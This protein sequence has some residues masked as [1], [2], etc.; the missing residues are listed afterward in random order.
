[1]PGPRH[2]KGPQTSGQGVATAK[3][4]GLFVE[5]NPE[6][7]LLGMDETEDD[8][9][10]EAELLALTGEAESTSRKPAPKGKT[11]L[12]MAHI[13]KLAA[14]CMRDEE[15]HEDDDEEGL[16]EDTD[17]LTEL[18]EVLG[19]SE[20]AELMDGDE[21]A[22][23][24]VCEEKTQKDTDPAV[25]T[26]LL[27]A[28]VSAV[29]AGG[30][31]GLQ[32][33]L[34]ERIQNYQHAAASAKEAGEA[35]KARR[36]ERGLKTLESQLANVR[37]GRKINEEEIPPPVALGRKPLLPQEPSRSPDTDSP[38]PS[39]M[40]PAHPSKPET[41]LPDSSVI[42][43]LP[44]SDPDPRALLLVRQREYKM[45]ALSA[46]RSGDLD[47]AR[48]LMKIGK[49]FAAVLEALEKG[50]PVDLSAMPPAPEDL[51]ASPQSST[52]STATPGVSPAVERVWPVMAPDVPATPG[53]PGQWD[54]GMGT[55]K[56]RLNFSSFHS[57]SC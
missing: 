8:G 23:P 27:M 18:Q 53:M 57:V 31:G 34:E 6:E 25:Q 29:Q 35:A 3:Q 10:L 24:G 4:L 5:F 46:K 7:M 22:S 55:R 54:G 44:D 1:M 51:K 43:A 2:R 19:V 39:A 26:P 13:E 49:K 41:S 42:A 47:R 37:K 9:D 45:A 20:E 11:P 32:A 16:E 15:E 52:A 21:A 38:A 40:D 36:C 17:L 48:E 50:Q 56:G 33:L 12:P 28:S 30:P 14:D